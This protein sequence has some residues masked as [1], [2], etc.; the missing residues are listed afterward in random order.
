MEDGSVLLRII[1]TF[2]LGLLLAV[3]IGVGVNTFYEPPTQP[4]YPEMI[5]Y[6]QK[7]DATDEQIAK[8]R[9]FDKEYKQYEKEMKVYNRNVSVITLVAS[10]IF[11]VVSMVFQGRIKFISDGVMLGGLFTLLYSVVR[12]FASED[13]KYLFAVVTVGLVIV[14]YLGYKRFVHTEKV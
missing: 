14:L 4:Q 6:P 13:S 3:F 12:G 5:T 2:F 10:V 7:E 1:Y 11:L 8:Q 9:A